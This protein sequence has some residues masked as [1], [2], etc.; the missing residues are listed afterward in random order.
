[1]IIH[2]EE[3]GKIRDVQ[4]GTISVPFTPEK[5]GFFVE[6]NGKITDAEL[7]E[8][9]EALSE[10]VGAFEDLAFGLKYE[11]FDTHLVIHVRI[12]NRGE[13]F[14]GRIGF[15][16]GPDTFMKTYPQWHEVFFPTLLRCEKTHLW[17]YFMNTA[18]NALAIATDRPAASW[19]LRYNAL[20]DRTDGIIDGG[21]RIYG[22]DILFYQ[23]T[24]LPERH[25]QNL[26]IMKAG[27]VYENR[28]YLIP[29]ERKADIKRTLSR[30][31]GIPTVDAVKYTK[32]PGDLLDAE[33]LCDS[34]A[35]L[36]LVRPDGSV[37]EDLS[38]PMEEPGRYLLKVEA[39]NGKSCESSFGLL[40]SRPGDRPQT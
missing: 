34:A 25:P 31:A 22:A 2:F 26:R 14:G 27:E 13:D 23:N 36:T 39:A 24:I 9:D 29:V 15:H 4:S 21:H 18:E 30:I 37:Q 7:T 11:I 19:D 8:K 16:I 5:Y 35:E 17:G 3:H 12:E 38:A 40:E 1:M 6:K 28:I 20:S 32:E 10:Y 33:V